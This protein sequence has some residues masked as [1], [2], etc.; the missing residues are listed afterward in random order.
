[1]TDDDA[2]ATGAAGGEDIPKGIM[3]L[4]F[5]S[6]TQEI[7]DCRGD[8]DVTEESPHKLVPIDKIRQDFKDRAAVSDFH[9]C[10]AEMLAYDGTE[11][12]VVYDPDFKYGQNFFVCLNEA[13]KANFLKQEVE[14]A[15]AEREAELMAEA[16]EQA[17]Q[18]AKR[19]RGWEPL[20]SEVEIEEARVV[21]SRPLIRM[22]I[23]RRRKFFGAPVTLSDWQYNAEEDH[24]QSNPFINCK[25]LIVNEDD[26]PPLHRS[27]QDKSTQAV[28]ETTSTQSQTTRNRPR[29][30]IVQYAPRDKSEISE[31]ES[32]GAAIKK[33]AETLDPVLA[34]NAKINPFLDDFAALRPPDAPVL[35]SQDDVKLKEFQSFKYMEFE[36]H[37]VSSAAWHP[38]LADV[39]LVTYSLDLPFDQ[40]LEHQVLKSQA[41]V[42][43]LRR[44]LKPVVIL[45]A[46]EDLNCISWCP[47]NPHFVAAGCNNG[48]I[49]FWDLGTAYHSVEASYDDTNKDDNTD[50]PTVRYMLASGID[51]SHKAPVTDLQWIPP[52]FKV[53]NTGEISD[54]EGS[55][56]QARQFLSSANDGSLLLW[57]MSG[58][59]TVTDMAELDLTW[60]PLLS[61]YITDNNRPG[62]ANKFCMFPVEFEGS[63]TER[64]QDL[65][66]QNKFSSLLVGTQLGNI[67]SLDWRPAIADNG[68][69][70]IQ[71]MG[72]V[73]KLHSQCVMAIKR[74][75]FQPDV[76]LSV[77]GSVCGV[78]KE[79]CET[80]PVLVY[81]MPG[82]DFVDACW[83]TI[84]PC[85]FF[86]A[87][88]DGA[89]DIWDLKDSWYK[90]SLTQQISSPVP[91]TLLEPC[92]RERQAKYLIAGDQNGLVRVVELPSIL[93]RTSVAEVGKVPAGRAAPA[94]PL[95][96]TQMHARHHQ[97]EAF[98]TLV[99]KEISV[100]QYMSAI[101]KERKEADPEPDAVEEAPTANE[102]QKSIYDEFLK[103]ETQFLQG[104]GLID[105]EPVEA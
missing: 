71:S 20:G 17:A 32:M 4:F 98:H 36:N 2:P 15:E 77:G 76:F 13:A 14:A 38:H 19:E 12:L 42:W 102:Q 92:P 73:Y 55:K 74:S 25:S 88:S 67:V 93:L 10:K 30:A 41:L 31:D 11:V 16:E 60:A 94:F 52:Q 95:S 69:I 1:M 105:P 48:Q 70:G 44:A 82:A 87:K 63:T 3:P 7:F 50:C 99:S 84:R 22:Q 57:D 79:K 62:L 91:L 104:L 27:L 39:V 35:S 5:T 97:S 58:D 65:R 86:V 51:T 54:N 81:S 56:P 96:L 53:A 47:T 24:P 89:I 43:N 34:A 23:S 75:P 33:L 66:K 78:W 68:K 80:G 18:A 103:Q 37:R 40:R 59:G 26:P 45:E 85:V 21:E 49:I 8:T 61:I 83:S 29:N 100:S 46:P 28:A 9:P 6:A 90:P 64:I 101:L 72:E